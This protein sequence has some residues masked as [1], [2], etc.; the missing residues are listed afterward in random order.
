MREYN[1]LSVPGLSQSS[2][3][4]TKVKP[5][6]AIFQSSTSQTL[7]RACSAHV[8]CCSCAPVPADGQHNVGSNRPTK[9]MTHGDPE[10]GFGMPLL[11]RLNV[12]LKCLGQVTRKP[13]PN[14]STKHV[15]QP[16]LRLVQPLRCGQTI[17]IKCLSV[18]QRKSTSSVPMHGAD[19]NL[20]ISAACSSARPS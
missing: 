16:A 19:H 15:T 18:I 13:N 14:A 4:F 17:Q 9:L 5:H 2:N 10:T 8:P 6:V 11:R 3:Y 7:Q 20:P 1:S 12:V